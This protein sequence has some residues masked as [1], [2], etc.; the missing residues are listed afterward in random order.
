MGPWSRGMNS[1]RY[2]GYY[3]FTETSRIDAD[4]LLTGWFQKWLKGDANAKGI[5][6]AAAHIFVMG[7]NRWLD[8]PSWPPPSTDFE[9]Y[10]LHSQG[11]AERAWKDGSLSPVPPVGF[12]EI[13]SFVS[14]P[15]DPVPAELELGTDDQRPVERREDVLSFTS[16]PL[17]K[18]LTV[19]GAP[20]AVLYA[21]TTAPDTD[22]FVMLTDVDEFGFSRPVS[23]GVLRARYRDSYRA[24]SPLSPSDLYEFVIDLTPTANT[25][26]TGHSIRLDIMGSYFPF[27]TRNLNTGAAI[28]L[29]SEIRAAPVF[30]L[31][32]FDYPSRLVLPVPSEKTLAWKKDKDTS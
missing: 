16:A 32:D 12:E 20:Q 29:D 22:L 4:A 25:F 6:A 21:N 8:L 31:H 11:H 27:L 13:D 5:P 26:L 1:E 17:E 14:D 2:L 9:P 18:D 15:A 24:P 30:I 23:M 3:D 10:F 28:G 7:S 19:I